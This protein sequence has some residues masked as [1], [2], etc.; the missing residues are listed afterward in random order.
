MTEITIDKYKAGY[1]AGLL[2]AKEIIDRI[3][4]NENLTIRLR[5]GYSYRIVLRKIQRIIKQE[6]ILNKGE[7]IKPKDDEKMS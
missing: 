5:D 3:W 6:I 4:I 7:I 2:R 1:V